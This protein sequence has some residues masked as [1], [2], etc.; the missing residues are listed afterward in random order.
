VKE[1]ITHSILAHLQEGFSFLGK[2]SA[3]YGHDVRLSRN[4]LGKPEELK[5]DHRPLL[6]DPAKLAASSKA[7][8][9]CDELKLFWPDIL[10]SSSYTVWLTADPSDAQPLF[11]PPSISS[12]SAVLLP[13]DAIAG[14][15]APAA[16][17]QLKKKN[18]KL[19]IVSILFGGKK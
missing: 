3:T 17:L 9:R 13:E 16:T 6:R 18:Q 15:Q 4:K 7:A 10:I 2:R 5:R 14:S 12:A 11:P 19:E 8:W 1:N